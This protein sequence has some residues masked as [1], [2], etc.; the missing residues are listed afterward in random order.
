[1]NAKL[2]NI[3]ILLKIWRDCER[4][5]QWLFRLLL[6]V[7]VEQ[8]QK[9]FP[10][11]QKAFGIETRI[12]DLQ[13]KYNSAFCNNLRKVLKVWVDL[14]IKLSNMFRCEYELNGYWWRNKTHEI[15][16]IHSSPVFVFDLPNR[17]KLSGSIAIQEIFWNYP[18]I[19]TQKFS[20]AQGLPKN[21]VALFS[22]DSL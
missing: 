14:I 12:V 10:K 21:L 1:M 5:R 3:R 2:R 18:S 6:L 16:H 15:W 17:E 9:M 19:P 7:H 13:K 8:H 4:S 20:D 11:T 22:T